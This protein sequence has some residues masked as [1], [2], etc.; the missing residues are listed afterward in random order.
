M[1]LDPHGKK[2][3]STGIFMKA[4]STLLVAKGKNVKIP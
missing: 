4:S 2:N 3:S 1:L